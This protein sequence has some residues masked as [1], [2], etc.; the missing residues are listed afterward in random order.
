MTCC[1]MTIAAR[2]G[3]VYTYTVESRFR[4][5]EWNVWHIAEHGIEPDEAEYLI[6]HARRPYPKEMGNDRWLVVG[7]L[8]DGVYAQCGYIMSPP[9]VVFVIHAR[10]LTEAEKRRFRRTQP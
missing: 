8:S 3:V 6:R 1:Q 7:Q 10:P 2:S 9:G 4:W 5:N